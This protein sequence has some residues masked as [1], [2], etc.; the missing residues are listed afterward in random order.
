MKHSLRTLLASVVALALLCCS[1]PAMAADAP[2]IAVQL[3]GEKLTF[4][5]AVPQ[6]RAGRTFLP[7]RAVFEAMGAEV[8][9]EGNTVSASRD[10]RTVTMTTGS[11]EAT[12]T[13][14]GKTTTLAMDVAPY[15][16][17]SVWRTYVP[18]RFAAQAFGCAVGWD[19]DAYTAIIIDAEKLVD[20]TLKGKS[21]TYLQKYTE[22]A[23]QFNEGIW[24][25]EMTMDGA[26]TMSIDELSKTPVK[27]P[28]NV[29][30][31]GVSS[32]ETQVEMAMKMVMDMAELIDLA[33]DDTEAAGIAMVNSMLKDGIGVQVRGDLEKGML[34]MNMSSKLLEEAGMSADTWYSMDLDALLKQAGEAGSFSELIEVSSAVDVSDMLAAAL[35]ASEPNDVDD[36]KEIK[37]SLEMA[38]KLL[39]DESFVKNGDNYVLTVAPAGDDTAEISLTLTMKDDKVVGYAMEMNAKVDGTD[40][41]SMMMKMAV[42]ASNKLSGQMKMA[43]GS[44]MSMD[45]T[46]SGQYTKGSKAPETEPPAGAKIVPFEDLAGSGAEQLPQLP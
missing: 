17:S 24:N 12:V 20:E 5:D 25:T 6:V 45:M 26:M 36:Y 46:I 40:P 38:A 13:E 34:Y 31:K 28:M 44:E 27:I 11:T 16:D 32:G 9:Y 37:A 29:T 18:V 43:M 14:D 8:S 21:F 4:T 30:A 35:A 10:G 2:T 33:G 39:S 15:V 41:T 23:Q 7:F 1:V 22:Y 42:D 19:Q 3:N